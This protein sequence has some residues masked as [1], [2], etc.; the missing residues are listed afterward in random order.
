M[1][2]G[3]G[4][5][6]QMELPPC[7]LWLSSKAAERL[8]SHTHCAVPWQGIRAG[9]SYLPPKACKPTSGPARATW[10][11]VLPRAPLSQPLTAPLTT[12]LPRPAWPAHA[13]FPLCL[14]CRF[15]F[16][17]L[18]TRRLALV[19]PSPPPT[20]PR[21]SSHFR[22]FNLPIHRRPIASPPI[23]SL[24]CTV[25]EHRN[26]IFPE[27]FHLFTCRSSGLDWTEN[28]L[29]KPTAGNKPWPRVPEQIQTAPLGWW[30]PSNISLNPSHRIYP[31]C[32]PASRAPPPN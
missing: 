17:P 21:L 16:P 12:H 6:A 10:A 9:T 13:P 18:N 27:D 30:P 14:V 28:A 7:G 5:W 25:S 2:E 1:R 15:R 3:R 8:G 26:R 23:H 31:P 19:S 29:D 22:F 4:G 24:S 11:S 20:T 32:F